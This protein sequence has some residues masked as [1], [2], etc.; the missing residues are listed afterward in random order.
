MVGWVGNIETVTD[1]IQKTVLRYIEILADFGWHLVFVGSCFYLVKYAW[2]FL[3]TTKHFNSPIS[4][5]YIGINYLIDYICTL[6][7]EVF[8]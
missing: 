2:S 4:Q 3:F 7:R 6:D 8:I 5:Y 1:R